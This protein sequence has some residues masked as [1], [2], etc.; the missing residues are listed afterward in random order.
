[1]DMSVLSEQMLVDCSPNH[2]CD[3]G[4]VGRALEYIQEN[5]GCPLER[6]YPYTAQD[7]KVFLYMYCHPS[8][9]NFQLGECYYWDEMSAA[10]ISGYSYLNVQ[11][12]GIET[13]A[14]SLERNGPSAISLFANEA[15]K[16]SQKS[17]SFSTYF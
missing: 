5:G 16:R 8:V 7:G 4:N 14:D 12:Y 11:T 13:L 15:F 6:D 1:M 3:G 9:H 10:K 2:G 17:L